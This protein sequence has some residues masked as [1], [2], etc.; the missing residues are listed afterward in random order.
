[1]SGPDRTLATLGRRRAEVVETA[2]SGAYHLITVLDRGGPEP[3]PGQFY[4]LAVADLPG[5]GAGFGPAAGLGRDSQ[6]TGRPYL[7]RAFS[8]AEAV[9]GEDGV[10]LSFVFAPVGPGTERLARLGVGGPAL[11]LHGPLGVGFSSPRR[12]NPDAA[13]AILVAG[14]IGIAPIAIWRKRLAATN[15]AV[16]TL[17]G[18]RDAAHC[19]GLEL[20]GKCANL[21]LVSE[22]GHLGRRGFVTEPLEEMLAG[23]GAAG[24][25]VYACG[26]PAMLEAVRVICAERAVGV[27]LALETPMGCGFGACFGC[28]VPLADGGYLR[29]CVDGPVVRGDRIETALVAGSGHRS[30]R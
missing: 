5:T 27:E 28:A 9:V 13:G 6:W 3:Q 26:P 24:A 17:L 4:M 29:L 19:G 7:P 2:K 18:F 15:T 1:M 30:R 21:V 10:R 22:D 25:A 16:R 20:F 23:D 8:V 12:L 14:G 11:G